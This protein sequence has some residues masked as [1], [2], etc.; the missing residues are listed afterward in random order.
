M[1]LGLY[2]FAKGY[3]YIPRRYGLAC[4]QPTFSN[5]A[6]RATFIWKDCGG[7]T[8][9]WHIRVTGGGTATN[10]KFQGTI[11]PGSS[12]SWTPISIETNDMLNVIANPDT[13]SYQLNVSNTGMDG[14]DFIPSGGGCYTPVGPALPVFVGAG[15]AQLT[16]GSINLDL[17]TVAPCN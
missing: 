5:S 2:R 15:R 14:I 4:G 16:I 10:L 12:L 3:P 8:N 17:N 9:Q 11:S 6:D 1:S 7:S 13:L